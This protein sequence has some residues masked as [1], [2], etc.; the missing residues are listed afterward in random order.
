MQISNGKYKA[1]V[2]LAYYNVKD[3]DGKTPIL[4]KQEAL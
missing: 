2:V 3:E 1:E 4:P